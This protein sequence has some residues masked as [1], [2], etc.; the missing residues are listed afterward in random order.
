MTE[1]ENT[2]NYLRTL[3]LGKGL[4]TKDVT[5]ATRISETNINAIED[6]NFSA[7]PADT[8]TRG[9]LTIYAEFLGADPEAVVAKFLEERDSNPTLQ[10]QTRKKTT[11]KILTPKRLAE[12]AQVSSMTMAGVLL[13]LIIVSFT[14]Y[15]FYTSWNPFS[16]LT[17]QNGSEIQSVMESVFPKE[18]KM[19]EPEPSAQV[20]EEKIISLPVDEPPQ[21][22]TPTPS[23]TL[24][25]QQEQPPRETVEEVIE[26]DSAEGTVID[27]PAQEIEAPE[28]SGELNQLYNLEISFLTKTGIDI[29]S[30]D[31]EKVSKEFIAGD[32]YSW[33]A[34][35]SF[36]LTFTEPDSAEII[37][38]ETPVDFPVSSFGDYSLQ[39]PSDLTESQPDE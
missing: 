20:L 34:S 29:V 19:P 15:C 23:Q 22:E 31:G 27:E 2:G 25:V 26:V 13:V 21:E 3:R 39:I 8:F 12:P 17:K 36:T 18:E 4:S 38:N 5:L 30:D 7:L 14:G 32:T 1:I 37:V 16:F 35:S 33:S 11:G 6:Q 9:L 28:E 10:K 24:E